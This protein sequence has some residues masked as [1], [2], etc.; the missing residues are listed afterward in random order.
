MEVLMNQKAIT[1][2]DAAFFMGT[3]GWRLKN[4][5]KKGEF[6]DI[7]ECTVSVEGNG[8][9]CFI[10]SAAFLE[11]YALTWEDIFEARIERAEQEKPEKEPA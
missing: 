11:K 5:I 9:A 10:K 1:I 6:A 3:S 7:A 8:K 2:E 4:L